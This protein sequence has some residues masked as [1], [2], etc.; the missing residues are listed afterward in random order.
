MF[1]DFFSSIQDFPLEFQGFFESCLNFLIPST[2]F[3]HFSKDLRDCLNQQVFGILDVFLFREIH[4]VVFVCIWSLRGEG[5]QMNL[6]NFYVFF[7]G[8]SIFFGIYFIVSSYSTVVFSLF[9]QLLRFYMNFGN[10][11]AFFGIQIFRLISRGCLNFFNFYFFFGKFGVCKDFAEPFQLFQ[12]F[13]IS[14]NF[15]QIFG[16]FEALFLGFFETLLLRST[17]PLKTISFQSF[18]TIISDKQ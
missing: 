8:Q 17:S 14:R 16:I 1:N 2:I 4:W 3:P 9:W 11:F 15:L 18:C 10:F 5:V 13:W 7:R 12:L 6:Y